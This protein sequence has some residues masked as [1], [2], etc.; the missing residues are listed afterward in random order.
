MKR[1]CELLRGLMVTA[2]M[3]ALGYG[4]IAAQGC[5]CANSSFDRS[6]DVSVEA[7][8]KNLNTGEL[9]RFPVYQQLVYA[10]ERPT[11]RQVA[12]KYIAEV[13]SAALGISQN[14]A[15]DNSVSYRL[16][17]TQYYDNFHYNGQWYEEIL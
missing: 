15:T 1:I 2:I 14:S 11:G 17:I 8:I 9:V 4:T 10:V 12:I 5:N 6:G 16:T 3:L 13:P 7:Y